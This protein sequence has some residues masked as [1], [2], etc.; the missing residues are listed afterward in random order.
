LTFHQRLLASLPQPQAD[1]QLRL[2]MAPGMDH[3]SGG[4]GP[5]E[6]DTLGALDA[7]ATTG[8]APDRIVATRPTAVA[9]P[10]GAP[11]APPRA[12]MSRPLCPYPQY[13]QYTGSGDTNAAENFRCVTPS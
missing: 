12:P 8:T 9:G 10:P 4:E 11:P 13:A 5:S 7:W 1:Q 2:F 3:C 6:F